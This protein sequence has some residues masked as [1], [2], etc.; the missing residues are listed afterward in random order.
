MELQALE[1][2][3]ALGGDG[4]RVFGEERA[5]QAVAEVGEAQAL[6][7]GLAVV[8][9]GGGDHEVDLRV[10]G[11]SAID[12]ERGDA[13]AGDHR[14]REERLADDVTEGLEAADSIADA[15]EPAVR[16][17]GVERED[18]FLRHTARRGRV[19]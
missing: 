8:L 3:V 6:H 9:A 16:P 19:A 18:A 5:D 13:R 1:V 2:G 11:V 17:D 10:I 15:L 14:E 12:G 7:V 4:R